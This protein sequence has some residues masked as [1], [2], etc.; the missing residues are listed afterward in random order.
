MWKILRKRIP[1][2]LSVTRATDSWWWDGHGGP[3][4]DRELLKPGSTFVRNFSPAYWGISD[5]IAH[6]SLS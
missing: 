6:A 3:E 5:F 1:K 2:T 4:M